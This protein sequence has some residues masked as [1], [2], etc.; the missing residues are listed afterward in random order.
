MGQNE[1][2]N[3]QDDVA[4]DEKSYVNSYMQETIFLSAHFV[5]HKY[6]YYLVA[7]NQ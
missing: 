6:S 4:A 7:N 3:R 5:K 2:G 1:I